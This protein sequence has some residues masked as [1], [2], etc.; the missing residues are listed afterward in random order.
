VCSSDLFA[1]DVDSRFLDAGGVG[2]Y[3]AGVADVLP[4]ERLLQ[5]FTRADE[6]L[7]VKPVLRQTVL[8]ARHNLLDDAPFTK[9]DLVVCRN[10]LIYFQAEAQERVMRR[11]QYALNPQGLLFLGSSE[12]LGA[13]Q[14]DFQA[15]DSA[16]KIYRLVRPVLTALAVRDGFGRS[17]LLRHVRGSER[18]APGGPSASAV[19]MGRHLLMQAYAPL[20]LLVGA[21]R[22]LLHAWGPTQRYLRMPQGQANL[23]AIRLLPPRLGAVAGQALQAALR[24]RG[25]HSAPPL[26]L[27]LDGREVGVRVVARPLPLDEQNDACVLL[28]FE[29]L[30]SSPRDTAGDRPLSEADIDRLQSMEQE[31]VDTR[32]S[33]QASLEEMETTNEELQAANEELMSS[34][35]ELQSTNEELQSFNEELYTVNAEYNAKLDL[36]SALHADLDGMSQATGIATLFVDQQLALVRFTP[37]ATLLFRLRPTDTGRSIEDFSCQLDYPELVDDLKRAV[38]GAVPLE[39]EVCG[40]GGTRF[41]ARVIGYGGG[42]GGSR[43]AVLSLID[44]S[45]LHD[46]QRL[47]LLIDSLPEHVALLDGQGTIRQVNMAWSRFARSNGGDGRDTGVGA[48]YLA[49]LARSD[50]ADAAA[51]LRGMQGVLSGEQPYLRIT[52]PCHSPTEERWFVMHA[53]PLRTLA[54]DAPAGAVVTHLDIT[55][56]IADMRA[57][58]DTR[59]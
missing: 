34:N 19:E 55:P 48:N 57:P 3:P 54:G 58:E 36:V 10:V 25:V 35:E 8:F 39:R 44:I 59:V 6:H 29:E 1:T 38:N 30:A 14:A 18:P 4:P 37:E 20:S 7:V 33:L 31:L 47:Q 12:S 22:Q 53:S 56:W 41:L 28:S 51:L 5:F 17:T 42:Q 50:S 11:L 52:Y 40:P 32:N 16:H 46:A 15:V 23:D 2:R 13:L 9:I 49:V 43:R 26:W 27:Q 45:R 21:G 24:D